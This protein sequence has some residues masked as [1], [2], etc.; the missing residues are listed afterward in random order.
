M[1]SMLASNDLQWIFS[2]RKTHQVI[3]LLFQN[4]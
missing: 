2:L 1:I 3:T 4:Y